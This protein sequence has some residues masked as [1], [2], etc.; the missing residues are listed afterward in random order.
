MGPDSVDSTLRVE[1]RLV[2]W[3]QG[4]GVSCGAGRNAWVE[5]NWVVQGKCGVSYSLIRI[6]DLGVGNL[7]FERK[8]RLA[9]GTTA[10]TKITT[11]RQ[12][13]PQQRQ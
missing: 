10:T 4:F 13:R 11:R 12:L 5:L 1:A 6:Y 3:I 2:S 9:P 7:G 8:H